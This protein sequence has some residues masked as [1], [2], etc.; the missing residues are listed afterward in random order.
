M[1][2]PLQAI[3][4]I[5]RAFVHDSRDPSL[6]QLRADAFF[7]LRDYPSAIQN[8]S[9]ALRLAPSNSQYLEVHRPVVITC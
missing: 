1:G 3:G 2:K 8:I 9:K 5:N 7:Q 6:Y 4:R